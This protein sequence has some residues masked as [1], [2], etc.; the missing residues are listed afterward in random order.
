MERCG[1]SPESLNERRRILSFDAKPEAGIVGE[2]GTGLMGFKA[3]ERDAYVLSAW[4]KVFTR[5]PSGVPAGPFLSRTA[6][7]F[8]R[9]FGGRVAGPVSATSRAG[10][11]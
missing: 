10:W 3:N 8:K 6:A 9:G 2:I 4:Q 7:N 11:L 5:R 1:R